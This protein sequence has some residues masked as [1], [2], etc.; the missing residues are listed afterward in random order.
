[1]L[2]DN[3]AFESLGAVQAEAMLKA[4]SIFPNFN[5]DEADI[6]EDEL[7][8]EEDD[9]ANYDGDAFVEGGDDE[10]AADW[11]EVEVPQ[12]PRRSGRDL[13]GTARNMAN[14]EQL[15]RARM[16]GAAAITG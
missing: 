6:V 13:S 3:Q 7:P 5:P 9:E 8:D 10:E 12:P 16:P 11:A 14:T 2:G 4:A 1:M 15:E